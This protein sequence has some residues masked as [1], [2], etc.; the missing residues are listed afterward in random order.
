MTPSVTIIPAQPGFSVAYPVAGDDPPEATLDPIIAWQVHTS[1]IGVYV[2]PITQEDGDVEPSE[3]VVRPDG[4]VVH[5]DTT[6]K[7]VAS[8]LENGG[9]A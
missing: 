7:S 3:A 6:Y 1:S 2:V 8:W 4:T 9:R 5:N